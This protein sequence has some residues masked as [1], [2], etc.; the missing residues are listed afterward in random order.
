MRV[1][2]FII[3]LLRA[4]GRYSGNKNR[5]LISAIYPVPFIINN[6]DPHSDQTDGINGFATHFCLIFQIGYIY[7]I[8]MYS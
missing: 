7:F 6:I 1:I 5:P 3:G 8:L 4:F 2:C